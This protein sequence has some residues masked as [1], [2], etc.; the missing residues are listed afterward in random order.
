[1]VLGLPLSL[2]K[3]NQP[4]AAEEKQSGIILESSFFFCTEYCLVESYTQVLKAT[5]EE[6]NPGFWNTERSEKLE[7]LSMQY[8]TLKLF[9]LNNIVQ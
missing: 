3:P 5:Y 4:Q 2:T 6:S 7:K 8:R 1:L 9:L